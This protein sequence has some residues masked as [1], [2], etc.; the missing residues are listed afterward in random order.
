MED[1]SMYSHSASE[2]ARKNFIAGFTH[3]LGG[4]VVTLV[5]W[6]VLAFI[7][8]KFILPELNKTMEQFN[9]TMEQFN[10]LSGSTTKG[11]GAQKPENLIKELQKLQ[12]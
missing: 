2:I 5:S 6:A 4:F 1:Q 11:T 7:T 12:N 3:A 9:T 8:V 10:Q